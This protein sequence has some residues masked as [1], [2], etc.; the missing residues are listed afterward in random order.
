MFKELRAIG[1]WLNKGGDVRVFNHGIVTPNLIEESK[2]DCQRQ[3]RPSTR[4]RQRPTRREGTTDRSWSRATE[5]SIINR[6]IFDAQLEELTT[7]YP[8]TEVWWQT[9]GFWFLTRCELLVKST[10]SAYF[11]T[12]MPFSKYTIPRSWGFW[13]N[14]TWIG[15]RHTNH[16]DGSVCSHEPKDNSWTR[17]STLRDLIDLHA[18]W[19]VRHLY[20]T[21]FG[22]WPGEQSVHE[23]IERIVE[24]SPHE[25]CGCPNPKG[26]YA[27]CCQTAD[28]KKVSI[29]AA[30]E[31][32][33]TFQ[34]RKPPKEIVDFARHRQGVPV[35]SNHLPTYQHELNMLARFLPLTSVL[36]QCRNKA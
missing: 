19:A 13:G 24:L 31:Y 1:R 7:A 36:L 21:H 17:E 8:D 28:L 18:V 14:G 5:T 15:S 32:T 9:D 35:L 2:N 6:S 26:H 34:V 23:P 33:R 25:R 22:T 4:S 27:D 11:L 3:R 30:I 16:G 29:Q 10:R 12:G 20:L